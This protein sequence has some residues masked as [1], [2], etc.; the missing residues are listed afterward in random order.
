MSV[1]ALRFRSILDE[2]EIIHRATS[3]HTFELIME[4]KE[5]PESLKVIFCVYEDRSL[6]QATSLLCNLDLKSDCI[7]KAYQFC[8][9]WHLEKNLPKVMLNAAETFLL[10]EWTWDTDEPLSDDF[11]KGMIFANFI[12]VSE[13]VFIA[14]LEENLYQSSEEGGKLFVINDQSKI[15]DKNISSGELTQ[16]EKRISKTECLQNENDCHNQE[17][18][19]DDEDDD[20]D[21]VDEDDQEEDEDCEDCDNSDEDEDCEDC[22]DSDDNE[23]S[24]TS[25]PVE[26]YLQKHFNQDDSDDSEQ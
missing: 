8:N 5:L 12:K 9:Q 26:H 15:S 23:N 13:S 22:D 6:I 24:E 21:L 16:R 18:D 14:A 19:E 1:S 20:S 11:L 10:C 3:P 25:L 4:T 17:A 2:M 7:Y